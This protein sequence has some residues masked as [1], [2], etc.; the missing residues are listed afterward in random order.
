MAP[1]RFGGHARRGHCADDCRW[2]WVWTSAFYSPCKAAQRALLMM[3]SRVW[4]RRLEQRLRPAKEFSEV[5]NCVTCE[6]PVTVVTCRPRH[7][8]LEK[9]YC[10]LIAPVPN[11]NAAY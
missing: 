2:S 3:V 4:G 11:T 8:H 10:S 1:L 7:S 9:R 6:S 5:S